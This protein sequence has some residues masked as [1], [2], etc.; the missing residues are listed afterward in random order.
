MMSPD[1]YHYWGMHLIWWFVWG[2]VLFWVFATPYSIPGQRTRKETPIDILK[3]RLASGQ[4]TN[5][6]YQEKKAILEA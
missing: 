1:H 4:I 5:Q 2:I 3:K 6:E